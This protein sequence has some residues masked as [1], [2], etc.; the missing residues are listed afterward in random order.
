MLVDG[1]HDMR[2]SGGCDGGREENRWLAWR[3]ERVNRVGPWWDVYGQGCMFMRAPFNYKLP[4]QGPEEAIS[5]WA[6]V[7]FAAQKDEDVAA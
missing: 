5:P 6:F 7:G 1:E 4:L 3:C 2:C